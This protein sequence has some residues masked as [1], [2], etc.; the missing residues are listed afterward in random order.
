MRGSRLR[1]CA[2]SPPI[3][4]TP[5]AFRLDD[6]QSVLE[7]L[8]IVALCLG[9]SERRLVREQKRIRHVRT[10]FDGGVWLDEYEIVPS[11]GGQKRID[12]IFFRDGFGRGL[13]GRQAL[14]KQARASSYIFNAF[15]GQRTPKVGIPDTLDQEI[16]RK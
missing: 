7:A 3:E 6:G 2:L 13:Q 12:Q 11:Y 10:A 16:K 4:R 5:P 8:E 14:E 9:E 1:P 15:L